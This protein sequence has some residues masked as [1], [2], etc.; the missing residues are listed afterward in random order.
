MSHPQS[1]LLSLPCPFTL[2]PHSFNT[3]MPP[4]KKTRGSNPQ[5]EE[6]PSSPNPPAAG[7]AKIPNI[8][9]SANNSH[10]IWQILTE[11]EKEENQK[12]LF[13]KRSDQVSVPNFWSGAMFPMCY[14][15]SS[16]EHKTSVYKRI[17]SVVI[18][19]VYAVDSGTAGDRVKGRIAMYVFAITF[20]QSY[21]FTQHMQACLDLPFLRY[22]GHINW[23]WRSE[24]SYP[25][26]SR[27]IRGFRVYQHRWFHDRLDCK[28]SARWAKSRDTRAC[29][30][31]LGYVND[32]S[33]H[34]FDSS[35]A[36][37]VPY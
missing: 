16:S 36:D 13:G 26:G 9:W 4:K 32:D 6:E 15:N 20:S 7:K 27:P 10:L 34:V 23:P 25:P 11:A 35:I 12:V 22:Q 2:R 19:D 21:L 37:T 18:P 5:A 8:D 28:H 3:S 33:V 1:S 24:H 29:K 14:K 31:C 30:E 17:A